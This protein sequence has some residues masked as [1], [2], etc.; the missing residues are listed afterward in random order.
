MYST[1]GC[2]HS[3]QPT[4][5][6]FESPSVPCLLVPGFVRWQTVQLLLHPDEHAKCIQRAFELYDVPKPEGG[7][8]PKTIPRE[9]FPA[10]PDDDLSKWQNIVLER[11][12]E[13]QNRLKNS[14]YWSPYEHRPRRP[15]THAGYTVACICAMGVELAPVHGMLD[16]IHQPISVSR[17]QNAY[18]LGKIYGH[19]IVVA[20]LPEIGNNAA[21]TVTTQLL[22][23]FPSIRFGLL[24]GV[25]GGVPGDEGEDDIRLGDKVVSQPTATFGGVVQF[26]L[27]KKLINGRFEKK[28]QLNKPPLILSASIRKLQSQ[29]SRIKSQISVHLSEMIRKN[30]KMEAQYSFPAADHDQLFLTSYAH[31]PGMTCANCDQQQTIFRPS[32]LDHEPRIHYGT[33]GS[34]NAVIKDAAVRDELK[35]DMNILCV[36]ME[37]AGLMDNFPC[38]VIRGVCDYADS[39]KNKRWQ[40]YAAAAA[41]A[42]MRE[43]L[44]VIPTSQVEQTRNAVESMISSEFPSPFFEY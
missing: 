32:R 42:Y 12:D 10:K 11:L 35:R 30:P 6:A 26:D 18:T 20:V 36:E 21:A 29:H 5:N 37:A 44:T 8:F 39:H 2:F 7:H 27:G 22:N 16:E 41:S 3:L 40:P 25:G 9:S 13:G 43:L 31:Q 17:D 19:N 28:G 23:D 34:A 15:L 4:A 33:T 14:S 24:V 38:L 1:L